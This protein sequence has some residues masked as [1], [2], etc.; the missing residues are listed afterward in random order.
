MS[1]ILI[2]EREWKSILLRLNQL[3]AGLNSLLNKPIPKSEWPRIG[4]FDLACLKQDR[5]R[6]EWLMQHAS[7]E[8]YSFPTRSDID[9]A[10]E[11]SR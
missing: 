9:E 8:G 4:P 1:T 5:D 10:M 11:N 2:E 7:N 3:E 6:L